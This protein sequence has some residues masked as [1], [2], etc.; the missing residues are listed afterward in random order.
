MSEDTVPYASAAAGWSLVV[1]VTVACVF[2]SVDRYDPGLLVEPIKAEFS[3]T[4]IQKSA[5]GRLPSIPPRCLSEQ[6]LRRC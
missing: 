2:S 5:A 3:L 6:A 1:M 4:D